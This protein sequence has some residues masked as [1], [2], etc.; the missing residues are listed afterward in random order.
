MCTNDS[1]EFGT[2]QKDSTSSG[3]SIAGCNSPG[4]NAGNVIGVGGDCG[5]NCPRS[6]GRTGRTEYTRCISAWGFGGS[7]GNNNGGTG[8]Q[9]VVGHWWGHGHSHTYVYGTAVFVRDKN[10]ITP[11][12]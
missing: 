9:T 4:G 1:Q 2:F 10:D 7:Y 5:E 12:L 6:Y 8:G 11:F 3:G